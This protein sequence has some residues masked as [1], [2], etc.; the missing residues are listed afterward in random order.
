MLATR[1]WAW[2]AGLIDGDGSIQFKKSQ[3]RRKTCN[4]S[5]TAI[6]SIHMYSRSAIEKAASIMGSSVHGY[7]N[8]EKTLWTT[9]V[10]G[11]KA[12][13]VL[14]TILPFLT[15]KR[16]EAQLLLEAI[17]SCP[18]QWR[19]SVGHKITEEQLALREGWYWVL[20]NAKKE[21]A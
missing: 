11:P 18:R 14:E 13:R 10:H 7:R 15:A 9:T 16:C 19:D 4:P 21:V 20:R 5:Y 6:V 8:Y 3:N 12:Q 17:A 2:L 1:W